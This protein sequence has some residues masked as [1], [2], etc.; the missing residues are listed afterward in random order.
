MLGPVGISSLAY[1]SVHHP[2][3]HMV[4]TTTTILVLYNCDFSLMFPGVARFHFPNSNFFR[5]FR[6]EEL[7]SGGHVAWSWSC[8]FVE[9]D[10][11]S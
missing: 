7:E 8:V 1:L 3:S 9:M 11:H 6:F 4:G 2:P 10:P 5:D